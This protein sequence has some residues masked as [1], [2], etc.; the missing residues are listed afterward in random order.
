VLKKG[1]EKDKTTT[2]TTKVIGIIVY[3]LFIIVFV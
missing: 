2:A 3:Y 1:D